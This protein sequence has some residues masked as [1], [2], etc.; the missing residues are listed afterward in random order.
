M[1]SVLIHLLTLLVFAVH[2]VVGC[3]A[4]HHHLDCVEQSSLSKAAIASTAC[5]RDQVHRCCDHKHDADSVADSWTVDGDASW[6]NP[7]IPCDHQ[8]HCNGSRC[9]FLLGHV[10]PANETTPLFDRVPSPSDNGLVHDPTGIHS[11]FQSKPVAFAGIAAE[12]LLQF[13]SPAER[14]ANQQSWLL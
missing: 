8:S 6:A 13:Y 14:C 7:P 5:G 3:C 1:L 4:H 12:T 11:A 2:A 9:S 10:R